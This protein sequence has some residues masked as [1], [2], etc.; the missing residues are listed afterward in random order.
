[1]AMMVFLVFAIT[2]LSYAIFIRALFIFQEVFCSFT[3]LV[4]KNQIF[5]A[6]GQSSSGRVPT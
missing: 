1:M 5:M 4:S 3:C 2:L 6:W